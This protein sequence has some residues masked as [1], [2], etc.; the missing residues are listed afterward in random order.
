MFRSELSG[1]V[2]EELPGHPAGDLTGPAEFDLLESLDI[3]AGSFTDVTG[4][5]CCSDGG[6][7]DT[8]SCASYW[9]GHPC[10][11]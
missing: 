6:W 2:R 9:S 7:T 3:F 1:L 10:C 5:E 8:S 11:L 4:D